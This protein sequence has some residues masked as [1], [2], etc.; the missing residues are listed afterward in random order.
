[1]SPIFRTP[2]GNERSSTSHKHTVW[3]LMINEAIFFDAFC[4]NC[5]YVFKTASLHN[6]VH[7][8]GYHAPRAFI[9]AQSPMQASLSDFWTLIAENKVQTVLL[10]CQLVEDSQVR[11]M[12]HNK[13]ASIILV[14]CMFVSACSLCVFM[15]MRVVCMHVLVC[16]CMCA[17]VITLPCTLNE[18][19]M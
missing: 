3:R 5:F 18:D 11:N 19:V 1:M 15:C 2:I 7:P 17:N 10:L 12:H 6:L 16:I 13:N 8:Q 4:Q 14:S 9:A